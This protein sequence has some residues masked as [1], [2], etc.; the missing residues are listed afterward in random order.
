MNKIMI[1]QTA[2]NQTQ[3]EVQFEQDTVWLNQHQIALLFQR[4]RTVVSKHISNV[5]NEGELEEKLVCANFA[6]TSFCCQKLFI[7]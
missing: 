7:N 6:H 3:I 2:D 4:D 1:Y 5:F